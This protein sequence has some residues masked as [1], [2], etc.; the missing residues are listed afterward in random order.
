MYHVILETLRLNGLCPTSQ[1]MRQLQE[2]VVEKVLEPVMVVTL[3][4]TAKT[5]R[6]KEA[7]LL[8]KES[9]QLL[10][11]G[12]APDSNMRYTYWLKQEPCPWAIVGRR[13]AVAKVGAD[14]KAWA[15]KELEGVIKKKSGSPKDV[16][17]RVWW[18]RNRDHNRDK[19]ES[20]HS[21]YPIL[22]Q[23]LTASYTISVPSLWL[24][25]LWWVKPLIV[26][27]LQG[28]MRFNQRRWRHW[29]KSEW[30]CL[31]SIAWR[32]GAVHL[33]CQ[34]GMMVSIPVI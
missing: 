12:R 8:M 18:F 14:T 34:T 20:P 4:H 7:I 5:P 2:A 27:R 29:M 31:F 9:F 11:M 10:L 33:A 13:R 24:R 26:A 22:P 28:W 32:T 19:T 30:N 3:G 23:N 1:L 25:L 16:L 17:S 6:I 21:Y 15:W